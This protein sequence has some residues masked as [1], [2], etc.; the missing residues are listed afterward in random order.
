MLHLRSAHKQL[1]LFINLL[2]LKTKKAGSDY[3]QFSAIEAKIEASRKKIRMQM[4]S[5]WKMICDLIFS[6]IGALGLEGTVLELT[7]IL[8]GLLSA[9]FGIKKLLLKVE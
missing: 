8:T 9:A 3:I 7:S 6:G 2:L 5:H 1:K 4:L